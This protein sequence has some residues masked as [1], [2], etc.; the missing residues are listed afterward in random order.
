[1]A[2]LTNIERGI[3]I[4]KMTFKEARQ[5]ADEIKTGINSIGQKLLQLYEGD[6]WKALGYSSWRECGQVEFGFKQSH[7]YRLLDAA[8]VER[9]ISPNGE[10][11][12]IAE[13]QARPLVS[14][15]PEAQREVW[16]AAV[17]TA[18]GGRV[19]AA[20]VQATVETYQLAQIVSVID[21]GLQSFVLTCSALLEIRDS[22]LYRQNHATFGDYCREKLGIEQ[23]YADELIDIAQVI[24]N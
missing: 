14:L 11:L 8:E 16:Q 10:K 1:M 6:G 7:I 18:P 22:R 13:S 19:T 24:G 5:C 23:S 9:N 12:Q 17:E 4:S 2:D 3:V 21:A 20:H 15:P